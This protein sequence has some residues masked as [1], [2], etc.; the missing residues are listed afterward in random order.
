MTLPP[1]DETTKERDA[2]YKAACRE[3]EFPTCGYCLRPVLPGQKWDK[4]HD[5]IPR[6]WGGKVLKVWHRR[7]NRIHGAKV[8]TPAYAKGERQRKKGRDIYRS[9]FLFRTKEKPMKRTLD[10]RV[11]DRITGEPWG[12]RKDG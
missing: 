4:A 2:F 9:R 6:V 1:R 12:T 3:E 5:G 10:G 7:C 11:V 8:V